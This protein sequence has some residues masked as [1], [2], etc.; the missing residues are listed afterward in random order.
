MGLNVTFYH[1]YSDNNVLNKSLSAIGSAIAMNPTKDI[2]ILN[3]EFIVG[4]NSNLVTANYCYVAEFGRYYY[5]DIAV[6]TG[7]RL[8]VRCSVDVLMSFKDSIKKC[9]INVIRSEKGIT[10]VKD[11]KLPL[12]PD[13]CS[14]Q[15]ILFPKD[16]F[17]TPFYTDTNILLTVNGG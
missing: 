2:T 3:P 14:L 12:S 11:N 16:P 4:Y 6:L 9:E 1:N 13:Q 10:Y 5:C 15:G 17:N 8:S 7:R